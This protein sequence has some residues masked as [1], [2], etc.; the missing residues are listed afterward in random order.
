M[1]VDVVMLPV[2]RV[3]QAAQHE[4]GIGPAVEA[5]VAAARVSASHPEA[6]AQ[7]LA[8]SIP[9]SLTRQWL[10]Q[11]GAEGR[12]G[13]ATALKATGSQ[14]RRSM[15][16][17]L[18]L[19]SSSFKNHGPSSNNPTA[20]TP[21]A[22]GPA[23]GSETD[24]ERAVPIA[25]QGSQQLTATFQD[26]DEGEGQ[27]PGQARTPSQGQGQRPGSGDTPAS[28]FSEASAA[29]SMFAAVEEPLRD[30]ILIAQPRNLGTLA[31]ALAGGNTPAACALGLG[32]SEGLPFP[33]L[34][35][36]AADVARGLQVLHKEGKAHGHMHASH[37]VLVE[38]QQGQDEGQGQCQGQ[39]QPQ[40]QRQRQ[41]GVCARLLC[42]GLTAVPSVRDLAYRPGSGPLGCAAFAEHIA[43]E[44]QGGGPPTA[45]GDIWA[46]GMLMHGLYKRKPMMAGEPAAH[47]YRLTDAQLR[48]VFPSACPMTFARLVLLCLAQDPSQRWA[49]L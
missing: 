37:V 23:S 46:L 33:L 17:L 24:R 8:F 18:P 40:Q 9:L 4:A 7:T 3:L 2:A 48:P 19:S 27:G 25:S 1:P 20:T 26:W 35:Q 31:S 15:A 41:G 28:L 14:G 16:M 21:L 42:L 5:V 10:K 12:S 45:A 39:P 49:G 38:Q 22:V 43:P 32:P 34:L 47:L 44:L 13:L 30:Y 11:R 29:G 36:L 6:L